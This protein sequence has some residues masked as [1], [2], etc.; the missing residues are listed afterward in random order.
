MNWNEEEWDGEGREVHGKIRKE[1]K[2]EEK[3]GCD[4]NWNKKEKDEEERGVCGK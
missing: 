2:G 3:D 1:E 4:M